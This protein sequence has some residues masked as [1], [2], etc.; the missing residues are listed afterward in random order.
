MKSYYP[1]QAHALGCTA[2]CRPM[3]WLVSLSKLTVLTVLYTSLLRINDPIS[4]ANALFEPMN[5]P[6]HLKNKKI[7]YKNNSLIVIKWYFIHFWCKALYFFNRT[8]SRDYSKICEKPKL[9]TTV[10]Y[11]SPL[12]MCLIKKLQPVCETCGKQHKKESYFGRDKEKFKMTFSMFWFRDPKQPTRVQRSFNSQSY[13]ALAFSI[14]I[15]LFLP[16]IK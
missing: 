4:Q 1:I 13:F 9:N 10:A 5:P 3:R 6:W 14:Y 11:W 16:F 7:S 15:F 2:L 8:F 12:G